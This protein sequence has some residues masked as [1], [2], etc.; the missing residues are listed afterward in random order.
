MV[1]SRTGQRLAYAGLSE[2]LDDDRYDEAGLIGARLRRSGRDRGAP[3]ARDW[4]L[5]CEEFLLRERL[6]SI[7]G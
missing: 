7:G 2:E 6:A 5:K 3:G 4:L 1:R